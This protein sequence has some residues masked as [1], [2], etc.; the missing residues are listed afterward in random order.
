M[1]ETNIIQVFIGLDHDQF[2]K[3]LTVWQVN[4]NRRD[5]DDSVVNLEVDLDDVRL[6]AHRFPRREA[7]PCLR[8]DLAP[9][10]SVGSSTKWLSRCV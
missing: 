2:G 8:S 7:T 6:D 3:T 9:A 10:H 4:M 5:I 1:F